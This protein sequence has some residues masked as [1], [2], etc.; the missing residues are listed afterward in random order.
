MIARRAAINWQTGSSTHAPF[1]LPLDQNGK[2][3]GTGLV[4]F[5]VGIF[6]VG[7]LLGHATWHAYRDL[8]E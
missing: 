4:T 3:G 1:H 6:V 7:P 5:L 8:L 2:R